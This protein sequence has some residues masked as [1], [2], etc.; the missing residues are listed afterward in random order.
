MSLAIALT[1]TTRFIAFTLMLQSLEM[2]FLLKH[3]SI[4]AWSS[5]I[6][7]LEKSFVPA[8]LI[9]LIF[10]VYS[11]WSPSASVVLVLFITHLLICMRFRG[12]FNGGSDMMIFV[13]LTGLFVSLMSSS[14]QMQKLGLLY[15]A[16]HALYSYFKAGFVKVRNEDWRSGKALPVFLQ[17]SLYKDIRQVAGWL[18]TKPKFSKALCWLVIAFELSAVIVPFFHIFTPA[19]FITAVV[20][21]FVIYL[22]FGLNRFFWAWISAWPALF[23]S[24]MFYGRPV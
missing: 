6:K 8:V 18:A 24:L 7:P 2:L 14:I 12:T 3:Q 4:K 22:S 1:L 11:L 10:S 20:F 13:V 9:Q 15:I 16:V 21:H 23:Y 17:Q 5:P 19:Y